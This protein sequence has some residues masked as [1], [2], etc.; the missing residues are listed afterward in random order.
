MFIPKD[1]VVVVVC[2][3]LQLKEVLNTKS[4]SME[5]A[6]KAP[7]WLK[8]IR[9]AVKLQHD[10]LQCETTSFMCSRV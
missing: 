5:K 4:F 6:A 1:A 8:E 2:C 10:P 9:Y 3:C 7:G